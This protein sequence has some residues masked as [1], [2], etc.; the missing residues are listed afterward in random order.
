VQLENLLEQFMTPE[1]YE[2]NVATKKGSA[3]RV[4]FAIKIPAKDE[5]VKNLWLPIDSKF[6][7]E[8]F[9]N[10]I[11]AEEKGD[12]ALA[13]SLGKALENRIKAEAK[14]IKEKYLDPPYTTDFGILFLPI[15]GLFAEVIR[16]PGL[17]D[18]LQREC[19]VMV[20]GP[21]T[22]AALLNSLQM[23]FRTLAI[24][25]RSSEVWAVL[26]AVRKEFGAFGDILEKTQ[27]KLQQASATIE[28]AASK[29]R[30]I[31]RK[32]NKVQELPAS[33]EPPLG[34]LPVIEP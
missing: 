31:E 7:L 32:L 2:K 27:Q 1:Q 20:T 23:G 19:R 3:D 30:N 28:K 4:E 10:L 22:I 12:L 21:T 34:D 6:P 11:A 16:R 24:E 14:Y 25:K 5:K 8:D 26:G 15:E 13:E 33:E 17:T 18:M 29:S 9:Q